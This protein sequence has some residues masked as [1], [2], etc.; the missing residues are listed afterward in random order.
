MI[1]LGFSCRILVLC[2]V[3]RALRLLRFLRMSSRIPWAVRR[4]LSTARSVFSV[5]SVFS[6]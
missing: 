4:V 1:K 6:V 5:F 2:L 3:Y